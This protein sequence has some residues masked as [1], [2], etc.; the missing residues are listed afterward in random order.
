MNKC[1]IVFMGTPEFSV[2]VLK[3]LIKHYQVVG[4]VCQPDKLTGRKKILT[5]P[6]VKLVAEENNIPVCQPVRLKNELEAILK[7]KPD[8]IITCA[9]GQIL[10]KE[11]LD[12]PKYGCINI[13]ASLLPKLRGGAPIHKAIMHNYAKTGITIMYMVEKMDAGDILYQK[14]TIISPND[15]YG[16]LEERLSKMGASLIIEI[17]PSFLKGQVSSIKQNEEE[18]TYAYNVTREDEHIDFTQR[19]L[20]I[21]NQIRALDP[22]P[23]GF[24][25]LDGKVVKIFASKI[26]DSFFTQRQMGEISRIYKDGIGVNTKDGEIIITE[27]QPDGKKRMLVKDYLNG[28]HEKTKELLGKVLK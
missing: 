28:N 26:S 5:K 21:Y 23:G 18:V 6:P 19:T 13:H 4:V 7:W 8:L 11:L 12:Y 24:A 1:R 16:S 17:L 22:K 10:P 15:T 14:E 20:D 25:L 27:I 2:P 9:Y 3:E